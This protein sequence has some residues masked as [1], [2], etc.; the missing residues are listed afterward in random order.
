MFDNGNLANILVSN[1]YS[2]SLAYSSGSLKPESM[3]D[4]DLSVIMNYRW[5]AQ[6]NLVCVRD[7]YEAILR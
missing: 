7:L 3:L 6:G 1:K 5:D 4:E 2:Y